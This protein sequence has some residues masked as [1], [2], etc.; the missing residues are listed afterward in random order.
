MSSAH[1]E[2]A[3]AVCLDL[4]SLPRLDAPSV[5]RVRISYSKILQAQPAEVVYAFVCSLLENASWA[6]RV[7]AWEVLASHAPAFKMLN[8]AEVE[9]M[10]EGLDDWASVDLFGVT[11]LGRA[12]REGLVSD[13]KIQSWTKSNNRWRRRL[14]L[15]ATVPLN[16]KARGGTGDTARTIQICRVLLDDRDDMVVKAMSWALRELAK[17]DAKAVAEFVE[18][19]GNRL[20]PRIKREV[21]NKLQT[22]HK[23]RPSR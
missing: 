19:E 15:V 22:G 6:H 12:W 4:A 7:V 20:A 21:L 14:A 17:R 3:A 1:L 9:K 2:F 5:R 13:R 8:D 16:L 18:R 10:A 11:V 23:V